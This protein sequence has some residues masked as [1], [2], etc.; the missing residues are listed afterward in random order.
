MKLLLP[1]LLLLSTFRAAAQ[2][3]WDLQ[4]MVTYAVQNNISVRQADV[5]QRIAALQQSLVEAGRYP[6]L[7]FSTSAGYNFGRSINPATNQ[8]E[9]RGIFFQQ[10]GLQSGVNLFSW[11]NQRYAAEASRLDT[12]AAEAAREKASNDV[13]LNVSVAYLQALLA[14]EQAEVSRSQIDLTAARLQNVRRQVEAGS[15]PEL[16]ALELQAQLALD[17]AN[18][19]TA[20]STYEQNVIQLKAVLNLD[21]ATPFNIARPDVSA[22]P[23]APISELQPEAVFQ[24]ALKNLPQQRVNALRL[25]SA[26]QNIKAARASMYPA[27]TGF[28]NIGSNYSSLFPDQQNVRITPTN[29]FDTLGFVEVNPGAFRPA[30]RPAF[31]VFVPQ[32]PYFRQTFDINLS[33]AIGV[34]L[35]VPIFQNKQLRTAWQR[36]KLN[37][38][39]V[40]L[41][42]ESD[43]RVLQQ[44]I[45]LAYTNAVNALQRFNANQRA[46]ETAER[47][48]SFSQRRYDVG[49][50]QN[51]ELITNQNNL[52][53]ARLD[54]AAARYEY[55]FRLK[56]LEFYKGE[57]LRL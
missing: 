23:V 56:L 32:T 31:D 47:T 6:S 30:L 25:Q 52:Y 48:L 29:R 5:Q 27:L 46:V 2:D 16:R 1:L 13:A 7:G 33:Q 51:I 49:L 28:A 18:F 20:R 8:F 54:A 3:E 57:G 44:D 14:A 53:R 4:R 36:A 21:M 34:Q 35:N 45:Y 55:V 9:N 50:L 42:L 43:N 39:T 15:L 10:F 24:A 40:A 12:K 17:S 11:F 38:E 22:I 19:I 26:Y 37:A 41:Q